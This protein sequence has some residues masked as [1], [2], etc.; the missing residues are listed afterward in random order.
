MLAEF[1][2]KGHPTVVFVEP[3]MRDRGLNA[4]LYRYYA[5]S[6][7]LEMIVLPDN[8]ERTDTML[9]S[10]GVLIETMSNPQK[11]TVEGTGVVKI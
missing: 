6:F 4:Y 8:K 3:Q 11:S 10:V 2:R 9:S 7:V 5:P 1:D